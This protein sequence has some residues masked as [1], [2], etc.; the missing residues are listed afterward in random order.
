MPEATQKR[1]RVYDV[2]IAGGGFAG[3]TLALVLA[4]QAPQGFRIALVDAESPRAGA[5]RSLDARA[6]AL[7]AASKSLL[8][9]LGSWQELEPHAQAISSIEITDSPLD[10]GLRQHFLGFED[11]LKAGETAASIV[12]SGDLSRMLADAVAGERAIDIIA[13]DTVDDFT[14]GSFA[15]VARL[16]Q[17]GEIEASLLVAADGK[18]STF[19][20]ALEEL[21]PYGSSVVTEAELKRALRDCEIATGDSAGHRLQ[22]AIKTFYVARKDRCLMK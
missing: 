8:S 1:R 11:E 3:R 7:S 4:K 16:A 15:V 13:P 14:P 17:G 5:G 20:S 6:L 9:V 18:R 12:E 21:N 10:A 2:A 19:D 22:E